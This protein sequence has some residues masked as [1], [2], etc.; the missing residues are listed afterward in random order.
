MTTLDVS[1][2][3]DTAVGLLVPDEA[4][5]AAVAFLAR[6]GGRTLDAYRHDLRNLFQ[7]AADHGTARTIDLAIGE[8][9]DGP[10]LQ[11]HDGQHLDRRTAHRWVR[12]IGKRA[13]LGLVHPHMPRVSGVHHGC[14]R[15]RCT[16]P[17]SPSGRQARR[18]QNHHCPIARRQDFDRHAA[19]VEVAFVAGG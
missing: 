12:S 10:I 2:E 5:L 16:A 11:R 8:R 17:R 13:E 3:L 1:A 18:P 9:R 14:P 19:Y 4:Q 7:W 15:R 6:Y